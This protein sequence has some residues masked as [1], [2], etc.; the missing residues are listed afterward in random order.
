MTSLRSRSTRA[1]RP[2]WS[3]VRGLRFAALALVAGACSPAEAPAE[4][5]SR[6]VLL[7]ILD[8]LRAD[9]LGCYG[10][11]AGITP[12]LDRLAAE[13]VRF[14]HA[15]SHAPWTLPAT[16]SLLSS[17]HPGQHGAGGAL[18]IQS[19]PEGLAVVPRFR[20][21]DDS[22]VT[23]AE[24][25][26]DAGWDTAAVVNVQF[27]TRPFG[28]MQGFEHVDARVSETNREARSAGDTTD[29]ALEWLGR[30]RDEP[31]FLLVHYFD[32]HAV[33]AP[34]EEFRRRFADPEDREGSDFVFGT[35]DEM[36][37]LR[38]GTLELDPR[39][40]ER[41]ERLYDGEVAYADRQ[42]GRLLDGLDERPT[43]RET[44]AR[45]E[46][47]APLRSVG[48]WFMWRLVEDHRAG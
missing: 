33:Y 39:T 40:L 46:P 23:V 38:A 41:A 19:G 10:N 45:G 34:P 1:G 6:N 11:P 15:Y 4:E 17:L 18:D 32:P 31:F 9:R 5:R 8:T 22:V 27:L 26:A 24:V 12:A 44:L 16:A 37:R 28:L 25:F 36:I 3:V 2:R 21:L 42:I 14:E 47:W 30:S 7:V 13:G 29:A 20:A 48:A 43:E 35:R